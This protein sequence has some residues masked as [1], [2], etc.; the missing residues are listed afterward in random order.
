MICV[1]AGIIVVMGSDTSLTYSN[2]VCA[3]IIS[4]KYVNAD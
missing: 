4:E 3:I 1:I 2:A